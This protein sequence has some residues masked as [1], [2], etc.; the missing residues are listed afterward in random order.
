M[1]SKSLSHTV[2]TTSPRR[3]IIV[4]DLPSTMAP[5]RNRRRGGRRHSLGSL[6]NRNT[7]SFKRSSSRSAFSYKSRTSATP[8]SSS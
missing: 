3:A 5:V 6:E 2:S 7:F 1:D 8:K 4:D